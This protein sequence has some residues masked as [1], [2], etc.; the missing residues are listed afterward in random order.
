MPGKRKR[1]DGHVKAVAFEDGAVVE[2]EGAHD[3]DP[4]AVQAKSAGDG[5]KKNKKQGGFQSFGLNMDVF[6]GVMRMGYKLPTPIQ[7]KAIPALM[8]GRDLVAM[9]RTGSGKTAAFLVPLMHRLGT[10]D[11]NAG[12]RAVVLSPTRELA[13]QTDKV[14]HQLGK[15]TKLRYEVCEV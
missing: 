8:A 2:F 15:F 3:P 6:K 14:S 12:T 9:A 5:K 4:R 1:A 11:P 13:V 7:R 10:R